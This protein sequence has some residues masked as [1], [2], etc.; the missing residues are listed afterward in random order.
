MR[1]T[2][3][4]AFALLAALGCAGSALQREGE[5]R[6]TRTSEL[7]IVDQVLTYPI[8]GRTAQDIAAALQAHGIRTAGGSHAFGLYASQLSWRYRL[9][10]E[11]RTRCR[12]LGVSV[13]LDGVTSVA[14]WVPPPDAP[15][16][17]VERWQRLDRVARAHEAEHR[18]IAI[19]HGRTLRGKLLALR[20]PDCEG[21]RERVEATANAVARATQ[22]EQDAFDA[23]T[24]HGI[25]QGLV[26][27]VTPELPA[28][29]P[30]AAQA[31]ERVPP[32]GLEMPVP[33]RPERLE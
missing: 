14:R 6:T 29:D 24:Q 18:R 11:G 31:R 28:A 15:R 7:T 22:E 26:W 30:T 32:S 2:R 27:Y 33:Q 5:V 20:A 16:D 1:R 10:P 17:V 8:E 12:A 9:E 25:A 23:R 21:L 19:A 4:V 3:R 13:T